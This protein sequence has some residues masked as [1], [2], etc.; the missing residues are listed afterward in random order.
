M[1]KY[2]GDLFF[3]FNEPDLVVNMLQ[4]PSY[5]EKRGMKCEIVHMSP[6]TFLKECAKLHGI[7]VIREM[8]LI[9]ND[10]VRMYA[11]AFMMGKKADLPYLDYVKK[12][13]DGRNRVRA[14]YFMIEKDG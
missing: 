9:D 11:E 2:K 14:V 3:N 6:D 7:S 10:K 5:Y 13:Q 4:N 8:R 12:E 1:K